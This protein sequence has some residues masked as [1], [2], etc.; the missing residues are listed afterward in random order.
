[1]NQTNNIYSNANSQK[2][3]ENKN[4]GNSNLPSAFSRTPLRD[5]MKLNLE[6][7]FSSWE[8]SSVNNKDNISVSSNISRIPNISQLLSKLP[9]PQNKYEIDIVSESTLESMKKEDE[10]I[11]DQKMDI[12]DEEDVKRR[13]QMEYEEE[14]KKKFLNETQ[15]IQRKLLRP[16]EINKTYRSYLEN[17]LFAIYDEEEVEDLQNRKNA[18]ELLKTEMMKLVEYDAVN[19]PQKGIKVIHIKISISIIFFYRNLKYLNY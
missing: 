7:D 14:Q 6:E 13:Q 8:N 15:V 16:I 2:N 5:E 12:E 1:L 9:K 19:H 10:E 18:E 3:I 4:K 11:N 17:K